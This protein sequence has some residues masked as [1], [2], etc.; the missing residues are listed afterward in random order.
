MNKTER[1]T[2]RVTPREK[3]MLL[4]C[5]EVYNISLSNFIVFACC[6]LADDL[7]KIF[8]SEDTVL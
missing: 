4:R 6:L 5:S 3:E 8:I 2:I 7:S 1:I